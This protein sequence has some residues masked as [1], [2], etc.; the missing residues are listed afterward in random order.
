[1]S[2]RLMALALGA[3]L[4]ACGSKQP[5]ALPPLPALPADA[6]V[7]V[8]AEPDAAPVADEDEDDREPTELACEDVIRDLAAYP[9]LLGD[10]APERDW[11]LAVRAHVIEEDCEHLWSFEH[12]QCVVA[13]GP[14][15]CIAQL[16]GD[17][18]PRLAKLGELGTKIT[19]ARAK[20]GT[21]GCK[22]VVANHYGAVRWQ[23]RL[24]GFDTKARNQMIADSRKIMQRACTTDSWSD[25]VRAC[26]VLGGADLC[27]FASDIRR[28]WG[29]PADGSVRLLGVPD[30]DDYDAAVNKLA[31]CTKLDTYTRESLLRM[32]AALKANIAAAP[33]A[34]RAKRGISCRAALAPIAGL[35]TDAGC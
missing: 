4:G 24:D 9:P 22:Q 17:L 31:S 20:P 19:D 3:T 7:A 21:I 13:R 26:L 8:D 14:V 35:A 16:P 10:D 30:C 29:Y 18:G 11:N 27:F 25:T 23:G 2:T 28:M 6:A 15:A 1:M 5:A 32:A 12:K 34:E 33:K